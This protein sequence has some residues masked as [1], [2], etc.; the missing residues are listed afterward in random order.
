MATQRNALSITKINYRHKNPSRLRREGV[1]V[2][3]LNLGVEKVEA[4]RARVYGHELHSQSEDSMQFRL[5]VS[6]W[7]HV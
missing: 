1:A 5:D 6:Q 4:G 3:A 2:D 7:I